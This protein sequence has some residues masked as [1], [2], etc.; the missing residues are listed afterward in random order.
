MR[1][2]IGLRLV[3]VDEPPRSIEKTREESG[4]R[5]AVPWIEMAVDEGWI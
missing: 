3:V 1:Q 2:Y 4:S 5:R